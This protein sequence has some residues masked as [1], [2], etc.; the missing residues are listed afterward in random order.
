MSFAASPWC[1][2]FTRLT[3]A[4][5]VATSWP[6]ST[7]FCQSSTTWVLHLPVSRLTACG[8]T[9]R[10]PGIATCISPSLLTS[11]Q[12]ERCLYG[13]YRQGEGV[14]ER[15]LFVLNAESIVHWS[16]VFPIGVNPGAE[17]VLSAL[18]ELQH[19]KES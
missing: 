14:S 3:G 17:G 11:S 13:V 6:S 8:A 10:L 5:F 12:R 1:S 16:Y 4:L 18:E 19:K 2:H 9:Q 7:K 15:A